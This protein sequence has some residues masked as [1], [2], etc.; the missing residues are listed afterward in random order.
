[1]PMFL[2]HLDS[3]KVA[4]QSP[5]SANISLQVDNYLDVDKQLKSS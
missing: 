2:S 1:M 3:P 4:G 5:N